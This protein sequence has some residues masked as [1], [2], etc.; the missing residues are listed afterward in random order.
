MGVLIQ[1]RFVLSLALS[2]VIGRVVALRVRPFPAENVFL[3]LISLRR[4]ALDAA[5]ADTYATLCFSTPLFFLNV[6]FSVIY[7]FVVRG[8]RAAAS[9]RLPPYSRPERCHDLYLVLGEQHDRTVSARADAPLADYSRA[10]AVRRHRH[11][12][13]HRHRQDLGLQRIPT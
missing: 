10:R 2:D 1:Y 7:I 6:A 5:L 11:C 8:D 4:P 3:G 13:R 12:R 9:Q